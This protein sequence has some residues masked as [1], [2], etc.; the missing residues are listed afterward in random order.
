[1]V[2]L[3]KG[4]CYRRLEVPYTRK[5][6]YKNQ[7][8]IRSVPNHKISRFEMGDKKK[9][10]DYTVKLVSKGTLQLRHNAIE[11][12]RMVINRR[13]QDVLG[14]NFYLKINVYPHHGLREN[15]MIGGAHA[16]RLQ[17]G[18]AHSFGKVVGVAAQVRRGKEIF[19]A[20]VF[21]DGIETAKEAMK[22]ATP[23]MPGGYG[24]DIRQI[25]K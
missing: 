25:A 9:D 2:G 8:Y 12:A 7:N 17:S 4:C 16:D 19:T 13:L 5:S 24:V 18:M 20:Y 6:K 1:M 3:R 10:Y 11:S 22:L 14:T 21:K 23:R 15:K